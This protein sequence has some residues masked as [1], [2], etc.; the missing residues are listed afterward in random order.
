MR[1]S[2]CRCRRD[3]RRADQQRLRVHG[4]RVIDTK[5]VHLDLRQ[6]ALEDRHERDKIRERTMNG[7]LEKL[8]EGK[9][10]TGGHAPYGYKIWNWE[11]SRQ[12]E[13]W[14]EAG[15]G[16]E[17]RQA[18]APADRLVHRARVRARRP[19]SNQEGFE[20]P[21]SRKAG[22]WNAVT[23][24]HIIEKVRE[25]VYSGKQT[26]KFKRES[27]VLT[28]SPWSTPKPK[29]PWSVRGTSSRCPAARPSSPPA[30]A[31]ASAARTCTRKQPRQS[32][33]EVRRQVRRCS[34]A[35]VPRDVVARDGGAASPDQG[36]HEC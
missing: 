17:E 34:R 30:S 14:L 7:K 1:T 27:H 11:E 23:V 19:R 3:R 8:S 26:I 21:K 29:R 2:A 36:A 5:G 16:P 6:E 25:G 15:A 35:S 28:Y 20:L 32:P 24:R 31:T 18:P 4:V 12:P 13:E 10:A 22:E 33:G 9:R